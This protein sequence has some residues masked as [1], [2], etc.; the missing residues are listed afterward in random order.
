LNAYLETSEHKDDIE[1]TSITFEPTAV[2]L[3]DEMTTIAAEDA[4]MFIAMTTGSSCSQI[5][6]EAAINGMKEDVP[7]K[8]LASGCKYVTPVTTLGEDPDG[9]WAV[10]GGLKDPD[11]AVY[12][13]DPFV[14]AAREWVEEAGKDI[15]SSYKLGFSYA[16]TLAQGVIIAGQ[17]DGGVTRSNLILALRSIDM[18]HPMLLGGLRVRTDGNADAYFIEG[19]DIAYW[20]SGDQVWV[21][22]SVV[23]LDGQT[24]NCHWDQ[25][26]STCRR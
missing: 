8:F 10:G 25:A 11:L 5:I 19:S 23:D 6:T 24:P 13:N 22:D 17:L 9:W 21:Q 2:T 4:D 16:W 14:V 3:R 26:A 7:Y 18:T 15:T 20:N 12:D 1:Y